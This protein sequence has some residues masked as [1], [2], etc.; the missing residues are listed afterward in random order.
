M[1]QNHYQQP[2]PTQDGQYQ[3]QQQFQA[4]MPQQPAQPVACPGFGLTGGQKAAWLFVG[5]LIGIAGILL[6]AVTNIDHPERK[7]D[8]IKFAAIGFVIAILLYIFLLGMMSC[9]VAMIGS[10]ASYL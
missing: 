8:A 7:S 4:P 9:S 5:L 10:S 6:A 1:N 2:M 3:P